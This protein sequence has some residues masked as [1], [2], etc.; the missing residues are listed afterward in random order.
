VLG[1]YDELDAAFDTVVGLSFDAMTDSEKVALQHRME[2][3]LRRAATIG[4]RLI[5]A[6]GAE[7]SP[8][9][10]GGTSLTDVLSSAL[11]ISK[12]E[13]RRRITDA[14]L[15]GPRTAMTGEPLAP[16]LP[17][18][19]AAQ[20]R[21]LIEAEHVQVIE[22]FFHQLPDSVNYQQHTGHRV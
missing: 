5:G 4:H 12:R 19:A 20:H 13:A 21:G 22:S 14:D 16:K 8:S 6:L 18:V 1:A 3:N 11:R 15:L 9:A 2:T 10:L 7:A 17:N